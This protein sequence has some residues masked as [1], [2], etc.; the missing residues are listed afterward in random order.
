MLATSERMSC[1]WAVHGSSTTRSGLLPH[2]SSFDNCAIKQDY[3]VHKIFLDK[4]P[5]LRAVVTVQLSWLI[6][7]YNQ[8]P[9]TSFEGQVYV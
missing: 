5:R 3:D 2:N 9:D 6:L 4:S 1:L 8:L 7:G